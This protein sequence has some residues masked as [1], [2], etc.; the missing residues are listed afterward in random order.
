MFI[1]N[2]F[3]PIDICPTH[4][5]TYFLPSRLFSISFLSILT[6]VLNQKDANN[7]SDW[8][9]IYHLGFLFIE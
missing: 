4:T 6:Y 2:K 1:K 8:G 3:D 5:F 7:I 9:N